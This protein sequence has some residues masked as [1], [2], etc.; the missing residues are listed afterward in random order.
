M[1]HLKTF[2]VIFH[3]REYE[4]TIIGIFDFCLI[5]VVEKRH[6]DNPIFEY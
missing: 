3:F 6:E 1:S 5:D 4:K 2:H